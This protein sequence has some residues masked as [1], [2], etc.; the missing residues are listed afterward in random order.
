MLSI[1]KLHAR[2]EGN[3]ILKGINIEVKPGEIHAIMGLTVQVK[4]LWLRCLRVIQNL[5]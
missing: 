5:K 2:V 3:E 4:V 1:K